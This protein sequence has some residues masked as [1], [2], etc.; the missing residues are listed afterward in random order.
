MNRDFERIVFDSKLVRIGAFRCHPAHPNFHD[1]GAAQNF[2]F[3][4]PRTAV[5][6]QHEHEPA[7]VANPNV[8]T[9]Y[10]RGQCYRRNQISGDGDRCDWFGADPQIVQ[11]VVRTF[12]PTVD[13]RAD[14][15]FALTHAWAEAN[16]YFLQRRVFDR[17]V[18]SRPI[19]PLS[20]EEAVVT[21][22][23]HVVRAAYGNPRRLLSREITSQQRDVVHHVEHVLSERWE[24]RLHLRNLAAEVGVSVYHLCRTFRKATGMTL[25]EYR[26]KLRVRFSLEI[27]AES[28][29]PL[30]DIALDAGFASHSH[31]TSTFHQEFA[32]PPSS[33]REGKP[34]L[35][36]GS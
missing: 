10:N 23:E 7:F 16:T 26:Q 15:P 9:F 31:F 19:E 12:D 13:S 20:I 14:Q 29:R 34:A 35:R 27:V 36:L 1:T 32:C 22:L 3:V 25:H 33:L 28:R 8:V 21:L 17:V 30:I 4:F 24:E 2:C 11:D 5:E 6:I 18:S